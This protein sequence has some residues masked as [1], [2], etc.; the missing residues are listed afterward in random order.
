LRPFFSYFGSKWKLAPKYPSP[1]H[2]VIVEPFAGSAGYA[3][4]H[5]D[6]EVILVEKS[7]VVAALWRWLISASVDEVM[8]LPID[9]A[10]RESLRPEAQSLIGF[11]CARGRT[12]PARTTASRWFTS[13]TRASSFWGEHIR[14]RIAAQ[15]PR[16]RHWRLIEG[17][18]SAAPNITATWFIDPPY[19]GAR[20]YTARV[21]SYGDLAAWCQNRRGLAIVCEAGNASWLPFGPL[22]S[23]RS[24]ARGRYEETVWLSRADAFA[25][26]AVAA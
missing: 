6:R 4:Q 11:W 23:A 25:Q 24:I 10:Q 14:G 1:E 2:D 22:H 19:A 5:A 9:P 12:A 15:V 26:G 3:T 13:G 7:P 8:A 18:Y 16:I 21:D 20:H 17:D